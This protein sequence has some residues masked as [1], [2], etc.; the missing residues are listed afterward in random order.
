MTEPLLYRGVEARYTGND[1]AEIKAQV[2]RVQTILARRYGTTL[3]TDTLDRDFDEATEAFVVGFQRFNKLEVDGIVGP[4]TRSALNYTEFLLWLQELK[5]QQPGQYGQVEMGGGVSTEKVIRG[6]QLRFNEN[7][8]DRIQAGQIQALAVDGI[9]GPKTMVALRAEV[10]RLLPS[11][12]IE[13][14][15]VTVTTPPISPPANPAT[16]GDITVTRGTASTTYTSGEV[17]ITIEGTAT[18]AA[19]ALILQNIATRGDYLSNRGTYT[20]GRQGTA[21]V[22]SFGANNKIT[23]IDYYDAAGQVTTPRKIENI[24]LADGT[25]ISIADFGKG[26]LDL[27][28]APTANLVRYAGGTKL[29]IKNAKPEHV[30]ELVNITE[31]DLT[32]LKSAASPK[33]V[34]KDGRNLKLDFGSGQELTIENFFLNNTAGDF[35]LSTGTLGNFKLKGATSNITAANFVGSSTPATPVPP[36]QTTPTSPATGELRVNRGTA[37]KAEYT[38]GELKV[39]VE[40]TATEPSPVLVLKNIAT[41][42]DYLSN[43]GLYSVGKMGTALV[44]NFGG[45]NKLTVAD[46]YDAAGQ[47][48]TPRKIENIKL[49]DGSEIAIAD[50]GRGVLNG[51]VNPKDNQFNYNLET[52]ITI[53][54]SQATQKLNFQ[55]LDFAQILNKLVMAKKKAS[56]LEMDFGNGKLLT[57]EGIFANTTAANFD[58]KPNTLGN[59]VYKGTGT[60][61]T[62]ETL[63]VFLNK[64]GASGKVEGKSI[65]P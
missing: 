27:S 56:N 54:N 51:S 26:M 62:T 15:T 20:V 33:F 1:L 57:I 16:T 12:V 48:T 55:N 2:D 6:F 34:N 64:L 23:I 65:G 11:L 29:T 49:A 8:K 40:G 59:I 7:H 47:A 13:T 18:A 53:Q 35:A 38:S 24:K 30:L 22:M 14:T 43:R 21:L 60:A 25:E 37:A 46:Y 44:V 39:I 5:A 9:L 50:F 41:Q 17:R 28:V 32:R 58:L 63:T 19:P 52:K 10:Q 45:N 42:A 3:D 4:Q 31:A 36:V 61:I